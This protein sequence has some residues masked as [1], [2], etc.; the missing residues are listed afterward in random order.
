VRISIECFTKASE[1][2]KEA[3][4]EVSSDP[5]ISII[6]DDY[7]EYVSLSAPSYFHL[8]N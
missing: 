4:T 2:L 5:F 3:I 8:V 1:L 6:G 7:S